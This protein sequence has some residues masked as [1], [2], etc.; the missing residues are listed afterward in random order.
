MSWFG[1]GIIELLVL[2]GG[3]YVAIQLVK[4]GGAT[5]ANPGPKALADQ[6]AIEKRARLEA[7]IYRRRRNALLLVAAALLCFILPRVNRAV[8][9]IAVVAATVAVT[10]VLSHNETAFGAQ[11]ADANPYCPVDRPG[12]ARRTPPMRPA[13]SPS[14]PDV[15]PFTGNATG[16]FTAVVLPAFGV[17]ALL[18]AAGSFFVISSG[19]FSGRPPAVRR[20]SFAKPTNDPT[21]VVVNAETPLVSS[22]ALATETD[23][24]VDDK[25]A[26]FEAEDDLQY[27]HDKTKVF[28]VTSLHDSA[29]DAQR[30]AIAR[31]TD[32]LK[33]AVS[34]RHLD[35]GLVSWTPDPLWLEQTMVDST[36]LLPHVG[37]EGEKDPTMHRL[38]L[39]MTLDE[40]RLLVLDQR[41][42]QDLRTSRALG[43]GKGFA[44]TVFILGGLAVVL[45]LGTGVR[46]PKEE[47]APR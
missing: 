9:M 28:F 44:G 42:D 20:V 14:P 12:A 25:T 11:G 21:V 8:T 2:A 24:S 36:T 22:S 37:P 1:L 23:L 4:R 32:Y 45:R 31:A 17:L 18:L 5:I 33:R 46:P 26:V 3:V 16:G 10:R 13:R 41:Y 47:A 39:G 7:R 19:E 27:R 38:R 35:Q 40:R 15:D 30:E 43:L 29:V 34:F 6:P